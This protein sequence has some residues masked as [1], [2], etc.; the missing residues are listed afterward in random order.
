MSNRKKPENIKND[1]RK[2]NEFSQ[3]LNQAL[4]ISDNALHV[5]QVE[6]SKYATAYKNLIQRVLPNINTREPETFAFYGS[7]EKYYENSFSYIYS[8]YPYDGSRLE[9]VRWS[10]SA[11]AIDLAV[12]QH[13]YPKETGHVAFSPSSWGTVAATSGKYSLSND[14]EYIKFSGGPYIG[15]TLNTTTTR[16]SSLKINPSSGNTVEFWLKKDSFVSDL[17]ESEIIFDSHTVGISE[18]NTKY[19]RFLLELSSSSGSP[20]HLTYMSGTHGLNRLQVGDNITSATVAD[21]KW[22]HY[23]F[24]VSYLGGSIVSEV[25]VDGVYD[26]KIFSVTSSMGDVE[27]TFN[28]TIGS[29]ATQKSSTGGLGYG[30]LSGSID[31]FRFWKVARTAEEINNNFDFPVHGSTDSENIN[32]KLGIYYKFNEGITGNSATDK[33]VLDYSGRL[34]NGEFIGYGSSNRLSTSAI[35]TTVATQE[36]ELGDPIINSNSERVKAALEKLKNIGKPYDEYNNSS[37]FKTV[38]QWAYEPNAGSS[39]LESDFSIL[40]QAIA[41]KFD[42]IKL[43]ID[44]IPKIGFKTYSDFSFGG[45]SVN[46]QPN[47]T[48]LLGCE[49]ESNFKFNIFGDTEMFAAQN[50]LAK[51]FDISELPIVNKANLNEYLY[52]LKFGQT[53]EGSGLGNFLMHSKAE[54]IKNK[55]LNSVHH[56]IDSI[57]NKKGTAASFRN[58]IRCFGTDEK[59]VAPNVYIN[60]GEIILK[61]KPIFEDNEIKALSIINNNNQVTLHQTSSTSEE[62]NSIQGKSSGGLTFETKFL[63]LDPEFS[64]VTTPTETSLFGINS[65]ASDGLTIS[66][67]NNAG[68]IVTTIRTNLQDKGC[69][70]RVSSSVG[71]FDAITTSYFNSAMGSYPWHLAVKFTEDTG[72]KLGSA[73]NMGTKQY[74]VEFSGYQYHLDSL[75]SSFNAS[76]S[77]SAANY[78]N[79]IQA[80]KGVY[81]GAQR[82]NV[83][84]SVTTKA[85][86]RYL[87]FTAWDDYLDDK[88]I[89]EHA[90][91]AD[92][93]GRFLPLT[94]PQ[95]NKGDAKIKA[96]T[97]ILNWIFDNTSTSNNILSIVDHSSGSLGNIS[98]F[99]SGKGYKYPAKTTTISDTTKIIS[100]EALP[101]VK[102]MPID[103][104]IGDS[105]IE[106]KA[107]EVDSFELDS[108]PISYIY[109]YEKSA[110]QVI[111]R[112]MLK[113]IAGISAYNNLIGEPIYKY[114]E[115]YKSLEKLRE[116]FFS[117]VENDGF[118]ERFI[119][120]YKWIDSSLGKMLQQLQPAT[121]SM[122]LGLEDVI[123]SHAFERN[124]YKHQA[125]TF[126][127]K[128]P[129]IVTNIL[130]VNEL[131]YDWKHGHAPPATVRATATIVIS[132]SGGIGHGDTFAL[133]DSRG[134]RTVYLVNGGVAPASGGGS[135]GSAVVG[136]SGVGGGVAGRVAAANAI[137]IAINKTTDADYSAESNGVNTVTVTQ[138]RKGVWGNRTNSDSIGHT[139]VSN[140]TG[141]VGGEEHNNCLWWQDRAERDKELHHPGDINANRE[142]LRIRANTFVS[143]STYVL[144]KLSRPYKITAANQ[145][146][147]QL[148]SNRNAN[149]NKELYKVIN[150]GKEITLNKEDIYEFKRCDDVINPQEEDL[151]TAKANTSNTSGYLD[152]DAD[153]IFPFSLYSSSV[154]DDFSNFK[155]KLRITNNHDD[156]FPGLQGPWVA[157]HLGGAAHRRV[158]FGTPAV[159]R[160]EAYDLSA[161]S[162]TLTVKESSRKNIPKS[163][164]SRGTARF[165]N[166]ANIKT[167]TKLSSHL[168]TGTKFLSKMIPRTG[169]GTNSAKKGHSVSISGTKAIVGAPDRILSSNA[170]GAAYILSLDGTTWTQGPSPLILSAS[171]GQADDQFGYS[172][173]ISGDRAI[174]GAYAE[175]AGGSNA[176]AAYVY[177][178]QSGTW[179]QDAKLV[180]GNAGANDNFG[181]SVAISGDT[182]VIGAYQEDTKA[183][184]AGAAYVFTYSDG[185]WSQTTMLTASDGG[186]SDGFGR[187]VDISGNTIVVGSYSDDDSVSNSGAAYVYTLSGGTWSQT[188]KLKA[189]DPGSVDNYG[190]SVA[191]DGSV[192]V[193]G[194]KDEDPGGASSA[195]SAYVYELSSGT[196]SQTAKLIAADAAAG[197][198]FALSVAVSGQSIIIGAPYDDDSASSAGSAYIFRK[199]R[200][201]WA[202]ERK[203]VAL[204][205]SANDKYGFAVGISGKNVII[206]APELDASPGSA[207]EGA[208]YL[209][210]RINASWTDVSAKTM[211]TIGNYDKVYEIVQTAGR[212]INNRELVASGSI[213]DAP[214]TR[215]RIRE[216]VDYKVHQRQRSEHVFV[217]RFS[218]PGGPETM[219][220][221]SRDLESGEFS[222]YNTINYRNLSVR[223]PLNKLHSERTEKSGYRSGRGTGIA[224][225][226]IKVDNAGGVGHGDTFALFDF[227]GKRTT[228]IING[229]VAQDAGGG[230]GG[231]ATVGFSGV[232]GGTAGKVK[233]ANAI[234]TAINATI[235]AEFSAVSDGIDTVTITQSARGLT[236]N[237]ANTDSITGATVSNFTGGHDGVA[238]VHMTNRNYYHSVTSGSYTKSKLSDNCYVQHPIPQNDIQYAWITASTTT[239][240][241]DL[242][243]AN[244]GFPHQHMFSTASKKAIQ[245]PVSHRVENP[246]LD[247]KI[248]PDGILS[249]AAA[250]GSAVDMDGDV[251]VVGA[252]NTKGTAS[253][254]GHVFI[255]EK[256]NGKF[257]E[258]NQLYYENWLDDHKFGVDV[259]VSGSILVVSNSDSHPQAGGSTFVYER[260]GSSWSSL[261]SPGAGQISGSNPAGGQILLSNAGEPGSPNGGRVYIGPNNTVFAA[262]GSTFYAFRKDPTT[263]VWKQYGSA[264]TGSGQSSGGTGFAAYKDK[265]VVTDHTR[266]EAHTFAL[267]GASYVQQ[268]MLTS[269]VAGFGSRVPRSAYY[270]EQVVMDEKEIILLCLTA[271][272]END[273][274]D[275][276]SGVDSSL[277]VY[278]R[279]SAYNKFAV[280]Q[281]GAS[282]DD[283]KP[284]LDID[285]TIDVFKGN[286]NLSIFS[287]VRHPTASLAGTHILLG[288]N[289]SNGGNR[290]NFGLKGTSNNGFSGPGIP[291]VYH[292]GPEDNESSLSGWVNSGTRIDDNQWHHLGIVYKSSVLGHSGSSTFPTGS[293]KFYVDGVRAGHTHNIQNLANILTN[294][295]HVSIGAEFDATP[296]TTNATDHW[297]G[298]IADFA[299]WNKALSDTEI[300]SLYSY[301]GTSTGPRDYLSHAASGSLKIWY[302][303][304]DG[305][306]A[307]ISDSFDGSGL[308]RATNRINDMS[309]NGYHAFSVGKFDNE[310]NIERVYFPVT[311]KQI[312]KFPENYYPYISTY[313][314]RRTLVLD[315]D[316]LFVGAFSK[317]RSSVFGHPSGSHKNAVLIYERNGDNWSYSNKIEPTHLQRREVAATA[318]PHVWPMMRDFFGHSIAVD[319]DYLVIGAYGDNKDHLSDNTQ[320]NSTGSVYVYKKT[321]RDWKN[322]E[323]N[324][325]GL[326]TSTVDKHNLDENTVLPSHKTAVNSLITNRQ[327]PYGWP[328]WKQ[329]RGYEHPIARAHKR[330]NTMSRVFRGKPQVNDSLNK[331][332]LYF[333]APS[334]EANA[335]FLNIDSTREIFYKEE[336]FS[337]F[338]W[339]KHPQVTDTYSHGLI[340]GNLDTGGNS[341]Q[342]GIKGTSSD[343]FT[344]PGTLAFYQAGG[345]NWIK[346]SNQRIDDNMWHHVGLVYQKTSGINAKIELYVDGV[347]QGP[348]LPIAAFDYGLITGLNGSTDKVSIGTDLDVGGSGPVAS[349]G[350]RGYIADFAIY[351]KALTDLEVAS[352]VKTSGI[353]PRERGP[354]DLNKHH[355]EEY[356][357]VWY[358][359]G[360]GI[361]GT[362]KDNITTSR[363]DTV[364]NRIFNSASR[365]RPT[366]YRAVPSGASSTMTISFEDVSEDLPG[367][368]F[369]VKDREI[370]KETIDAAANIGSSF[371]S[372]DEMSENVFSKARILDSRG[373]NKDGK[374]DT[375]RLIKNY[376]EIPA[377]KRFNPVSITFHTDR[378]PIQGRQIQSD[379]ELGFDS[380]LPRFFRK[381]ENIKKLN[382]MDKENIWNSNPAY[383]RS[384]IQGA[385]MDD[386]DQLSSLNKFSIS[387]GQSS[388]KTS[389]GND[390]TSFSNV[391]IINDSKYNELVPH[392][393]LPFLDSLIER[394]FSQDN[395]LIEVS[396]IEKIYPR[397]VNTYTKDAR[398]R[399]E[400]DFFGWK[401]SRESRDVFLSGNVQHKP[402]EALANL[403]TYA[404]FPNYFAI[405]EKNYTKSFFGQYDAVDVLTSSAGNLEILNNI[406]A[407]VWPLDSR[408]DF[409]KLPTDIQNSF[410]NDPGGFLPSR[411][412]GSRGE[413]ILQNDFS[414]FPLGYNGL[415]GTPPFSL[416]YNRRIPQVTG[417]GTSASPKKIYLAGEAKWEAASGTIGPFYDSYEKYSFNDIRPIAQDHSIV[418]EFR[419]SE[420]VEDIIKGK[421]EYTNIGQDYLAITGAVLTD[422]SGDINIGSQFFKTYSNSDFLKYFGVIDEHLVEQ[423]QPLAHARITLKCKAAMKFL[424]Y[425]GFY[426]A[427]RTVQLYELFHNNYLDDKTLEKAS[428]R[429]NPVL[430]TDSTERYLKLRANASRYQVGKPFFGPGILMNSI[431][432]GVAV[433]YPIFTSSFH[434]VPDRLPTDYPMSSW[435]TINI[436]NS[437]TF[438]GSEINRSNDVDSL[439]RIK[440]DAV[441]RIEFEDLLN[442]E[443][444][445]G[446]SIHDNEPHPS[447]SLQYGSAV[448]NRIIDRPAKVGH[449]ENESL[450]ET[451]GATFSNNK[452]QFRRQ[453][454]PYTLAVK[455]F[456]AET[457]NFF[458]D[459]GHLTTLVSK[460]M[461]DFFLKDS[462]HKMRVRFSNNNTV[463][464]DRHSAFGPPVDDVAS[465]VQITTITP[466]QT[467]AHASLSITFNDPTSATSQI[468]TDMKNESSNRAQACPM[469]IFEN[470]NNSSDGGVFPYIHITFEHS[471]V[472]S[473]TAPYHRDSFSILAVDMFEADSA[474][475][476]GANKLAQLVKNAIESTPVGQKYLEVSQSEATLTIKT[477][478]LGPASNVMVH[479]RIA[480]SGNKNVAITGSGAGGKP[481]ILNLTGTLNDPPFAGG[482]VE[483][484]KTYTTSVATSTDPLQGF[485][486]FVPPFLDP[487]SSPYVDVTFTAP[488]STKYTAKE[489]LENSTFQYFNF[490]EVPS[491]ATTNTNY[492]DSMSLSA[493]VNL[494]IVAT[495]K[496][497]NEATQ[498]EG[499]RYISENEDPKGIRVNTVQRT[500]ESVRLDRWV[501]QTKWETPVLDFANV[502]VTALNLNTNETQLV[503]GS[504]WKPRYWDSYYTK[505]GARNVLGVTQG[506][507]LTAST[508][509]WHQKGALIGDTIENIDKGYFLTVEDIPTSAG[510]GLATKMG[511]INKDE[512]NTG[513]KGLRLAKN[514]RNRVG[515]IENNKLVKEAVVAIPYIVREDLGNKIEFIKFKDEMYHEAN[516]NYHEIK[517]ELNNVPLS[518]SLKTIEQYNEFVQEYYSKTRS[519]L[520]S[521][522][523]NAIEYQMFM[524]DDF[525]LPPELDFRITGI[526][527]YMIY[528]FQFHASFDKNDLA[529]IW[530]NLSPQSSNSAAKARYSCPDR[531]FKGRNKKVSDVSY[532]SH[533]LD[534]VD[535]VGTSLSPVEDPYKLFSDRSSANKTRWLIFKV[536]QRGMAD[537]EQVRKA[538]IDPRTSNVE[539]FEYVKESKSSKTIAKS[540]DNPGFKSGYPLQFNWP[541]DYFSFVELIKLDAKIDSYNYIKLSDDPGA[542]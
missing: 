161:T 373:P 408:K 440:S 109:S 232:G 326:N 127:F 197:D 412:Q 505:E 370:V 106:I 464:Y 288:I 459:D 520:S 139:T 541:Y 315:G 304:G 258:V 403:G 427:E 385:P 45:G 216:T 343:F 496:A 481:T 485:M 99:G 303:M 542:S 374:A 144:R 310:N 175:D 219:A 68:L 151:Y 41:S 90:K 414:T 104:A 416:V 333:S 27:A 247:D 36:T 431:K 136:F 133:V 346:A 119:E 517:N 438:V 63:L 4:S 537:L 492:K 196:W 72:V 228:Y 316:T 86:A 386:T 111:S 490:N 302:R 107:R 118:L 365:Y 503:S 203:V 184:N 417:S 9:K 80:N 518:D 364:N 259:S 436:A 429:F 277:L 237:R 419:I 235:D 236:G 405:D 213:P 66:S 535:L 290:L 246:M 379:W 484:N 323:V 384:L 372:L 460:P 188:Q 178:L 89:K 519:H 189:S 285:S 220:P 457:V 341:W 336:A 275:V 11:S 500:E 60:N 38:P 479:G 389:Y 214:I 528:F 525:I 167:N 40:L 298:S 30:K 183:S 128:D 300:S 29:M 252:F 138:G 361:N 322:I 399:E 33:V 450:L 311:E 150:S 342:L 328:T 39:N 475:S 447:A 126:E 411:D 205:P 442:M 376:K 65:V 67:P 115:D 165:T 170:T 470:L 21:G 466:T 348:R 278:D 397:E 140:F 489:I 482:V 190:L 172:V 129:K 146:S 71:A 347:S 14:V 16:E 244:N 467:P 234:A 287:W 533:Y 85:E 254:L 366:K 378:S 256:N 198:E 17:T 488:A 401:D 229:G 152:A 375:I 344:A 529:N 355:C 124:K 142:T 267:E 395:K 164:V 209:Y 211:P 501:I 321:A 253:D 338:A 281:I 539:T 495:L 125:P 499:S 284:F 61:D 59:L 432:A 84:G 451:L 13:E 524:M 415:Y 453:M 339:V 510:P 498:I 497:D 280:N 73:N 23:A 392:E 521:S 421:R 534:T 231:S 512:E 201:V 10:L 31:E 113:T 402:D 110:Y 260:T 5:N 262:A 423:S 461:N 306:G 96:D 468:L 58:L 388:M 158:K 312:I 407:S 108:R 494:G 51:N 149:K 502:K 25:Y 221:A 35:T 143:G 531:F 100:T 292:L 509:M 193:V 299:V 410:F 307:S 515:E 393:F 391:E 75:I 249:G 157:E 486:P 64:T 264:I 455:N 308:N 335:S 305:K 166:I 76:S 351:N 130:G 145:I 97:L 147:L 159:D 91:S 54:Q 334:S 103:N 506:S 69:Q 242:L 47:F 487:N 208:V 418:P 263:G 532:V 483:T 185:S 271:S 513:A 445:H 24:V 37:I 50:L 332:A 102:Y 526:D 452:N 243:R 46:Y 195:G 52:N 360:D 383:Y 282:K 382:Q 212:N 199:K 233:A 420:F 507:F 22:H 330:D 491:N 463:M 34:N 286:D 57:Y 276:P 353:D 363:K 313:A 42:S 225:A 433:D 192:I 202:Q 456:T 536:K 340:G 380:R 522:P 224:T 294:T 98:D 6:S 289:S 270:G 296:T 160:P 476:G 153:M 49:R 18:G 359:M 194:A 248:I 131:L 141:G 478:W 245:F 120:Y 176:G 154:G 227:E 320:Q 53:D 396:Y 56:D 32:S 156:E 297:S 257:E 112:E 293:V 204:D 514:Y 448:F 371:L 123:E 162:T 493:S 163:K 230:S 324:Y 394:N 70:F 523:L 319:G 148:G 187:A 424:P 469:L 238:S 8:S 182:A 74:K 406:S 62:R 511:F 177:S 12:L 173:G 83:T 473:I 222:I 398:Q 462:V 79:F 437:T 105:K 81:V 43:L 269:S 168:L 251:L 186:F 268:G 538:S 88:E 357:K 181:F 439:Q 210:Q 217:N 87:S 465:G 508:G 477:R 350:W 223:E 135:N 207:N 413:G 387:F 472:Q 101:F 458:V 94:H 20:F 368:F 504:P 121:T 390:L 404:A 349:D 480:D 540:P 26:S 77:M 250:F 261:Q 191:V 1:I 82:A 354:I 358:R 7:A 240:K 516:V 55:I 317:H 425:R 443:N 345:V 434:T 422:P 314:G 95:S 530:Q 381:R 356:L 200:N 169:V 171:D 428:I 15:S 309:G 430:P 454:L 180:A 155:E 369:K 122:K 301:E 48:T 19:G 114:R 3:R 352:L 527:P 291:F 239:G 266:A 78:S 474:G 409:A 132:D 327:G 331:K 116:R 329:I 255:Y 444:V 218:S 318:R 134:K 226:T 446:E 295:D 215:G 426:P 206:G 274:G 377:T 362:K 273:G 279:H 400:F 179:Q 337:I 272:N 174:V 117:N 241:V 93:L 325:S 283:T 137:A 449:F 44:G 92:N 471:G 367:D 441:L 265:C 2:Q 435:A 28:G